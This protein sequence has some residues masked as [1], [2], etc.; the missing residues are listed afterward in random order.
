MTAK[1][2]TYEELQFIAKIAPDTIARAR[3]ERIASCTLATLEKIAKALGVDVH[4]LFDYKAE[5]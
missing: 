3:D 4:S 2:M 5:K 1:N